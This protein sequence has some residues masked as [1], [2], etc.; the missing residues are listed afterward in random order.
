VD[1]AS[2]LMPD[3]GAEFSDDAPLPKFAGDRQNLSFSKADFLRDQMK[4]ALGK[5]D[6]PLN[7]PGDIDLFRC[8]AEMRGCQH[9]IF[10]LYRYHAFDLMTGCISFFNT[11]NQPDDAKYFLTSFSLAAKKARR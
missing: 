7:Q 8:Q 11:T 10:R 6:V 2:P 9:D 3:N 5:R 4:W 1:V